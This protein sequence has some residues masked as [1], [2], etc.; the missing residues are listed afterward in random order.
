MI[1]TVARGVDEAVLNVNADTAAAALA[2]A[3]GAQRL[4]VLTDVEGLYADWPTSV[5]V[6]SRVSAV[7]LETL[8]PFLTEGMAPRMEAC[9]RAVRAG[10]P[11][12]YALDGR[13]PNAILLNL[14]TD[15]GNGT[16]ITSGQSAGR[17]IDVA[18]FGGATRSRCWRGSARLARGV[19]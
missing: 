10:V 15:V 14:F 4:V 2:V 17:P 12:A 18:R 1:A 13:V 8:L 9:L 11:E 6:L 19:G 7:D 5:V 3:V 16:L